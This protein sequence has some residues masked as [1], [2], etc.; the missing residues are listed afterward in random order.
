[1]R[2]KTIWTAPAMDLAERLRRSRDWAAMAAGSALPQRVRYWVTVREIG[3]A[4]A[5][6]P[7]VPATSLNDILKNLHTTWER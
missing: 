3:H 4:V 1:M 5:Y 6:S 2:L 7:D